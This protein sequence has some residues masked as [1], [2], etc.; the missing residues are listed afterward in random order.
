M[1]PI[2]Y[3]DLINDYYQ[4]KGYPAYRWTVNETAPLTPLR[5]PLGECTVSLLTSGGVSYRTAA[6][7]NPVAKDDFR[8]D[9]I[10]PASDDDAFQ[11]HDAYYDHRDAERDLNVL[12]PLARLRELAGD[13]VIGEV[14]AR[15][16]SGFMGRI[17][18][19]R[20]IIEE[21]APQ[22]ARELQRDGVDAIVMVPA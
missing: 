17:Y 2:D 21:A 11:I 22:F 5:K 7:F 15:L 1:K 12:F 14:A 19:R 16:W 18:K 3:V 8:V 10:D 6:P 4:S 9:E 20:H 13:G